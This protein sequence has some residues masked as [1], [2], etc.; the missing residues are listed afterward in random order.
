MS[1]DTANTWSLRN[2]YLYLV[3]LITLIMVIFST[4]NV[5]RSVVELV[6]PE[7]RLATVPAIPPTAE[8]PPT[9]ETDTQRT[10]QQAAY[11]QKWARRNAIL[12]LVGNAAMLLLAG[13]LYLYHWRKIERDSK[14]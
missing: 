10:E 11:Q 9:P 13:P 5:V 7:P 6:Y 1:A 8:R 3:C 12:N 2:I 14:T 4:V